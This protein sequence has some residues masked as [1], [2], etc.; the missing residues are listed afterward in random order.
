MTELGSPLKLDPNTLKRRKLSLIL[1]KCVICQ[2]AVVKQLFHLRITVNHGFLMRLIGVKM[3]FTQILLVGLVHSM[4]SI[5]ANSTD[6]R[7]SL[8]NFL[9]LLPPTD[10]KRK[11]VKIFIVNCSYVDYSCRFLRR[12]NKSKLFWPFL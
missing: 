3:K 9:S 2:K 12:I 8:P 1:E 7:G 6:L 11:N 10:L 4:I 5:H